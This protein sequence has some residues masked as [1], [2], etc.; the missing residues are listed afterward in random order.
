MPSSKGSSIPCNWTHDLALELPR[1]KHWKLCDVF[2][3]R[4]SSSS[5]CSIYLL[6]TLSPMKLHPLLTLSQCWL[7]TDTLHYNG[8]QGLRMCFAILYHQHHAFPS[9]FITISPVLQTG[10]IDTK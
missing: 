6:Q 7:P 10:W 2:W 8:K 1:L 4:L 9:V 5:F 3:G